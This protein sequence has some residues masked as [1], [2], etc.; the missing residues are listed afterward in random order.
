M[1]TFDSA[2]IFESQEDMI[3]QR[4]GQTLVTWQGSWLLQGVEEEDIKSSF[5]KNPLGSII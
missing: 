4:A 2:L 5:Y 1:W 3:P